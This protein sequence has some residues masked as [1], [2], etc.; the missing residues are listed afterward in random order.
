M[1]DMTDGDQDLEF[2]HTNDVFLIKNNHTFYFRK[3]MTDDG[4]VYLQ[5]NKH[6]MMQANDFQVFQGTN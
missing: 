3:E 1:L 4:K 6:T 5:L 2:G